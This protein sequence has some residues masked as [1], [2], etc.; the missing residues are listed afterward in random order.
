MTLFPTEP[1]DDAMSDW[2]GPYG[3]MGSI[4]AVAGSEDCREEELRNE[5]VE[6][7]STQNLPKHHPHFFTN[8]QPSS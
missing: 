3:D 7:Q 8:I 1:H 2:L 5:C 6:K 4:A